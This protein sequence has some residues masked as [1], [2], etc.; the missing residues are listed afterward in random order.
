[1]DKEKFNS[2]ITKL[3]KLKKIKNGVDGPSI[4]AY[5][6]EKFIA[7]PV[8]KPCRDCN[9]MVAGREVFYE[10]KWSRRGETFW[11]KKCMVC[12]LK[13]RGIDL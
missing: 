8:E 9:Q 3:G 7:K 1:M 13:S 12:G 4:S 11:Q 6:D 10:V 2:Q 5:V